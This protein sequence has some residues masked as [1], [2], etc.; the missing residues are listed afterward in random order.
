MWKF[1]QGEN[2]W[3]NVLGVNNLTTPGRR[4]NFDDGV[5]W[6]ATLVNGE[7]E[8]ILQT[9]FDLLTP[10][11]LS[12]ISLPGIWIGYVRSYFHTEGLKKYSRVE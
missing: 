1:I 6:V 3:S 2:R 12:S 5:K 10:T 7:N 11:C 9:D 4:E 8:L